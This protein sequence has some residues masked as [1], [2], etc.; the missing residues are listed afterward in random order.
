MGVVW[1]WLWVGGGD[2]VWRFSDGVEPRF[3]SY[4]G[5]VQG[6]LGTGGNTENDRMIPWK[7]RQEV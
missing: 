3:N 6:S 5:R 4:R 2:I 7:E 1:W